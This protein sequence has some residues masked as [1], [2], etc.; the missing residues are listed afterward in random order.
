[1][2]MSSLPENS[3]LFDVLQR[4]K[5]TKYDSKYLPTGRSPR[6]ATIYGSASGL[7]RQLFLLRASLREEIL[8]LQSI[9]NNL[10]ASVNQYIT[11]ESGTSTGLLA[12]LEKGSDPAFKES[13]ERL[14]DLED[15]ARQKHRYYTLVE[16]LY[17]AEVRFLFPMLR[18]KQFSID[19]Q[20]TV[21]HRAESSQEGILSAIASALGRAKAN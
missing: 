3:V 17:D 4:I 20:W 10:V 19:G 2:T 5:E 1:M 6:G 18:A 9:H 8:M 15:E 16:E 14:V 12:I 7:V 13:V 11:E 21:Y